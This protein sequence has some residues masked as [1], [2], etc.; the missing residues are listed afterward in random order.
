MHDASNRRHTRLKRTWL[1]ALRAGA[2]TLVVASAVLVAPPAGAS[3]PPS[4]ADL[5]TRV[6]QARAALAPDADRGQRALEELAWWGNRIGLGVAVRPAW[7]NWPNWNNWHNW[8]N[9]WG[10][11]PWGNL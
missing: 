2:G 8:P 6:H 7:P 3:T 5:D 4:T 11:G 1:R 10:N 9:G